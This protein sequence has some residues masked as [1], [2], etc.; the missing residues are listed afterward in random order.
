MQMFSPTQYLENKITLV[1]PYLVANSPTTVPSAL[2][3][4]TMHPNV[5]MRSIMFLF[6][7]ITFKLLKKSSF[8]YNLG[9][10]GGVG[11]LFLKKINKISIVI[12]PRIP[13]I[14]RE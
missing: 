7:N 5:N 4:P 13:C 10:L 14:N 12:V 8:F 2:K 9:A 6:V 11:G 1:K 3:T